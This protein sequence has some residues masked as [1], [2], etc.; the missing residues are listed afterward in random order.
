MVHFREEQRFRQWWLWVILVLLA[1]L[2]AYGVY[3]QLI[4]GQPW[5]DHPAPNRVLILLCVGY[6][7]LILWMWHTR[8]LTEV[9]DDEVEIRFVLVWPRKRIPLQDIA[10]CEARTYRPIWEYG[11]WGVR[12]GKSGRAF[13]VSGDRGVQLVL[14]NGKRLLIGSQRAEELAAAILTR[15]Q[16][17]RR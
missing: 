2:L 11:G 6:A 13:N 7:I 15:M 4:L 1:C 16:T 14:T 8:L 12:W 9:R 10:S 17:V 5:G 3:K